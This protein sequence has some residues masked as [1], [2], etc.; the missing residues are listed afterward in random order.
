VST[1]SQSLDVTNHETW[2]VQKKYLKADLFTFVYFASEIYALA[3]AADYFA[4]LVEHA[5]AG[6]LFLFV[7]NKAYTF[8]QWIA[9]LVEKTGLEPIL[10]ETCDKRLPYDEQALDLE[11]Y[12]TKFGR[13]PK[14]TAQVAC[15]VYRKK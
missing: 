10:T 11:P 13:S 4:Y 7:D 8:E 9:E 15:R 3:N 1:Y 12:R 14:L 5:K 2:S 6:A